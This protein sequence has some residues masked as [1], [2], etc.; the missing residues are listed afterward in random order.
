M[1][2]SWTS[3]AVGRLKILPMAVLRR[4]FP[5]S[6]RLGFPW[7]HLPDGS[8]TFRERGFVSASSPA[9]LLARHNYETEYIR[10]LLA[11]VIAT[12]SLE[13]GCG[14]GRLTPTF[15][16]FSHDHVAIDINT[17]AL[18]LAR[19]AYPKLSF[20]ASSV[21]DIPFADGS[22]DLISTWTVL[23]HV[24]PDRIARACAEIVRVLA[25]GG[26]LLICEETRHAGVPSAATH[27]WHRHMDEYARLL[28]PLSLDYSSAIVEIEALSYADAPGTVAVWRSP[29]ASLS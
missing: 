6:A 29:S 14:Y 24:P 5:K 11:G 8:V 22:F 10:R 23:Q 20:Q 3:P 25:P 1:C 15:A 18:S 7:M 16:S 28:K 19:T 26:T 13:I 4:L 21:A 9:M 27:T 2:K 17:T 12:K